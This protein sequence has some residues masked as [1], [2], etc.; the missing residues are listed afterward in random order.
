MTDPDTPDALKAVVRRNTEDVQRRGDFALFDQLF[1]DDFVDHTPQPGTTPDKA[2]VLVLYQRL[3]NAF[4]DFHP[5]IHWQTVDGDIVTTYKVYHGT[6]NGEFLGI[7][8]TGKRIQ[9]ET[10]DA[11]RV[12]DGKIT[13]HWGVANLYSVLQQ[14]EALPT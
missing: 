12:R 1:A 14:L 2:G 10:V 3:R 8:P 9:F 13:D 5:E 4:T 11:M 6:H 7:A